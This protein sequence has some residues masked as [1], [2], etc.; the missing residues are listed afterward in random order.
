MQHCRQGGEGRGERHFGPGTD[1]QAGTLHSMSNDIRRHPL[2]AFPQRSH[3]CP[4]HTSPAGHPP[5]LRG[6]RLCSA[7]SS[8]MRSASSAARMCSQRATVATSLLASKDLQLLMDLTLS[9]GCGEVVGMA[10][11]R[12]VSAPRREGWSQRKGVALMLV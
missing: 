9:L 2:Y 6:R 4:H 8:A 3:L 12:L 11:G 7:R 5:R 10:G 1:G